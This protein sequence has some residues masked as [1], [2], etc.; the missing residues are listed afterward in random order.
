MRHYIFIRADGE[1]SEPQ[2]LTD[3]MDAADRQVQK[4]EGPFQLVIDGDRVGQPKK[5]DDAL[6][7][8]GR[9]V[10]LGSVG[11]TYRLRDG[12]GRVVF[13]C[14]EVMLAP[15]VI[16]TSGNDKS[17]A[18]W[19]AVSEEFGWA[20]FLGSLVCKPDSQHRFGNAVDVGFHTREQ[21]EQL[22]R[23]TISNAKKF[24]VRNHIHQTTIWHLGVSSHYDGVPHVTHGHTDFDPTFLTSLPCGLRG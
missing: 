20:Y 2:P 7:T 10:L 5:R 18:Y 9:Q 12:D 3:V 14:R 6:A 17:D 4:G 16:D 23:F 1:P 8:L 11:P 19:T 22:A 15:E 21:G 24:S 13:T